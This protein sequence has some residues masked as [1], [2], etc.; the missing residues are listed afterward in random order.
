MESFELYYEKFSLN[1]RNW[2]VSPEERERIQQQDNILRANARK[3]AHI[4]IPK[5]KQILKQSGYSIH[6][7]GFAYTSRRDR[8]LGLAV[9]DS[10]EKFNDPV[11]SIPYIKT[12]FT[13]AHE[14][15][16]VLQWDD[17]TNTKHRRE[18]FLKHEGEAEQ[19]SPYKR[20]EL[21][22]LHRLWYELDAWVRGMQ[23]IPV[24]YKPKYKQYAYK[25]YTSYMIKFPR[26]YRSD[27]LLRNLLYLLNTDEQ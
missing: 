10:H 24:E 27:M 14:V 23:F 12:L 19:E 4:Y 22:E 2:F 26:D 9:K 6:K 15:G 17:E 7:H 18:E 5:L 1:P 11:L 13:L 8:K 16:H 3:Y 20:L 25:A 21:E